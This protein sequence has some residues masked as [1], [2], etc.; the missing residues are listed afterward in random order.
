[1][2]PVMHD[3]GMQIIVII[4]I[5]MIILI[6]MI[7]AILIAILI[8]LYELF[9]Y[10]SPFFRSSHKENIP[11]DHV[12]TML[13][14]LTTMCHFCLL[15]NISPVSVGQQTASTTGSSAVSSANTNIL[16]NLFHVFNP[17][18]NSRVSDLFSYPTPEPS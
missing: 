16:T 18:G 2:L 10:K 1:M 3:S 13:Q 17:V 12:L 5:M 8:F 6:I 9:W 14:G 15:D 7:I 11:P 4:L